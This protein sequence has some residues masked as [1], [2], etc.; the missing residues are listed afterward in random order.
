MFR[1]P[2][3]VPGKQIA[4]RYEWSRSSYRAVWDSGRRVTGVNLGRRLTKLDRFVSEN[5]EGNHRLEPRGGRLISACLADPVNDLL[6]SELLQIIGGATGI[7][8]REELD[9]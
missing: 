8:S 6:A 4:W 2:V 7:K 5:H 3:P 1:L 9:G